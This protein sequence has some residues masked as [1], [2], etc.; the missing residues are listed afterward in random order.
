M[1]IDGSGL[2]PAPMADPQHPEHT[3][4]CADVATPVGWNI[5]QDSVS[6]PVVHIR[7]ASPAICLGYPAL[8]QRTRLLGPQLCRAEVERPFL[9]DDVLVILLV[10]IVEPRQ[11][12]PA[13]LPLPTGGKGSNCRKGIAAFARPAFHDPARNRGLAAAEES[14][15]EELLDQREERRDAGADEDT[16]CFDA[17]E[18]VVSRLEKSKPRGAYLVQSTTVPRAYV[19]SCRSMRLSNV[20]HL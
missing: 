16:V 17:G 12:F 5:H 20:V 4:Y 7:H 18:L 13:L 3:R 14:R 1:C 15:S 2:Q 11:G 9:Q 19:K 10:N 6:V 8:V